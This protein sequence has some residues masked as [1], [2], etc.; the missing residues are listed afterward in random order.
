MQV[1]RNTGTWGETDGSVERWTDEANYLASINDNTPLPT[2][3]WWYY[4]IQWTG[5]NVLYS[6]SMD[7]FPNAFRLFVNETFA[8]ALNS[9]APGRINLMARSLN[10]SFPAVVFIEWIRFTPY[11]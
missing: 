10:A 2:I 6:W 3:P 11:P 4:R 5:T 7:G 1:H 8:N 9:V